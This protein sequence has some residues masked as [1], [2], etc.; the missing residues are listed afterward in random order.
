MTALLFFLDCTAQEPDIK[1]TNNYEEPQLSLKPGVNYRG[2]NIPQR[3]PIL[4]QINPAYI[5]TPNF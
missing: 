3:E 2:Y 5:L 4:S 1:Q